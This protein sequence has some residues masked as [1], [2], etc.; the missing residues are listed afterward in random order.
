MV[1]PSGARTIEGINYLSVDPRFDSLPVDSRFAQLV[2]ASRPE[3]R[4]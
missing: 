4:L 3:V 2:G 1:H